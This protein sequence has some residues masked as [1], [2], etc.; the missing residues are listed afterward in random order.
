M[1]I[2]GSKLYEEL[3]DWYIEEKDKGLNIVTLPLRGLDP[4]RNFLLDLLKE[5]KKILYVSGEDF[6]MALKTLNLDG[7]IRVTNDEEGDL[8]VLDYDRA[9][10][11]KEQ[12]DLLLYDDINSIPY[13]NRIEIISLLNTVNSKV[14]RI[15][16]YSIERVFKNARDYEVPWDKAGVFL[17][18]PRFITTKLDIKEYIP[19]ALYDFLKFFSLDNRKVII[20]FPDEETQN[21]F[22]Q[23][24][25]RISPEYL[26]FILMGDDLEDGEIEDV[27]KNVKNCLF[28]CHRRI[29]PYL[30][31]E[32]NFDFIV[33]DAENKIYSHRLFVYLAQRASLKDKVNGELILVSSYIGD[34]MSRTRDLTRNVNKTL[35]EEGYFS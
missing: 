2:E 17:T 26:D 15:I 30:M 14:E 24:L 21:G 25:T 33:L 18:E 11:I 16:S 3:K 13:H 28:I 4:L 9:L 27:I 20:L 1:F 22:I 23:Y 35:W 12:Y 29:R 10:E 8:V 32:E 34:N 7:E 6:N 19:T 31:V 5:G